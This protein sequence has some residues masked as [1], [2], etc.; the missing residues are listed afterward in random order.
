MRREKIP[1]D[2]LKMVKKECVEEYGYECHELIFKKIGVEK[3]DEMEELEKER[4]CGAEDPSLHRRINVRRRKALKIKN[5]KVNSEKTV[6]NHGGQPSE[7][8]E[9]EMCIKCKQC[10]F[11]LKI[12][13]ALTEKKEKKTVE[14]YNEKKLSY[15]EKRAK[16][17]FVPSER[18]KDVINCQRDKN[19]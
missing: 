2:I 8:L 16:F 10:E 13:Y 15:K 5:M 6:I 18:E 3:L 19:K 1:R 14:E 17:K 11:C 12:C 4:R 9:C 7:C